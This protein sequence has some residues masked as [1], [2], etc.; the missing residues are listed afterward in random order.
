MTTYTT[1]QIAEDVLRKLSLIDA[2]S[3]GAAADVAYISR[4]YEQAFEEW[5][6]EGLVYWPS[7]EIPGAV[8]PVI[9]DLVANRAQNAF[10]IPVSIADAQIIEERILRR[11]RRHV[12]HRLSGFT[13]KV[14]TF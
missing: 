2:N 6:D 3:S 8:A 13:T 10:G 14:D 5:S 12:A 1:T 4:V 11:L 9:I 7:S